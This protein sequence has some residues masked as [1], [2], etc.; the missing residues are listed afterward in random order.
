[1][2]RTSKL[3]LSYVVGKRNAENA[4][5][6]MVDLASRLHGR[7]NITTDGFAPYLEA[8]ETA[9]GMEV[10]YAELIKI[11]AGNEE[12]RGR[13]SPSECIGAVPKPVMGNPM[14]AC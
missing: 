11:Y 9:F 4:T 2:D 7:P 10:D 14:P 8:V 1:M 3:V 5:A 12:T 6:L 13:Y